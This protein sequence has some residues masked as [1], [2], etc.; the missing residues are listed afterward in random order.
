MKHFM[1]VSIKKNHKPKSDVGIRI[2]LPTYLELILPLKESIHLVI[3]Y[4]IS[5]F[6]MFV[7]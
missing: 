6:W 3:Q 5:V 4:N 1:L 7:M 2:I